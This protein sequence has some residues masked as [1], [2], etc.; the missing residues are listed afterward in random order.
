M[1]GVR[2]PAGSRPHSRQRATSSTCASRSSQSGTWTAPGPISRRVRGKSSCIT[3]VCQRDTTARPD[4][5]GPA[6]SAARPTVSTR[7][8]VILPGRHGRAPGEDHEAKRGDHAPICHPFGSV[9]VAAPGSGRAWSR[10]PLLGGCDWAMFG[11][12]ADHRRFNQEN[13]RRVGE[14]LGLLDAVHRADR[15][16]DLLVSRGRCRSR[17]TWAR[18]TTT[19]TRSTPTRASNCTAGVAVCSP[20]WTATTGGPVIG[21]PAVANGVVFVGS[22]DH[23]LYAFDAAGTTTARGRPKTC[24]PLWTATDR[25]QGAVVAGGRGRGRLRRFRRRQALRVRRDRHHQLR[26]GRP[27]SCTPLW[28]ATTGGPVT[29]RRGSGGVV[30][31]GSDDHKLYAFDAAG[32]TDCRGA[33]DLHPALDR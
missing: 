29:R 4:R 8:P 10:S 2:N 1:R 9:E 17:R 21:S 18:A 6:T 3:I 7:N 27:R 25:R 16:R 14:P 19:S 32:A 30:Y 31:V 26:R 12:D 22:D 15:R 20:L 11:S 23:K 24:I 5:S 28:T 33:E 13:R